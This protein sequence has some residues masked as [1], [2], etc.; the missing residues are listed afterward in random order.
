MQDERIKILDKE[1]EISIPEDRIMKAIDDMAQQMNE[2]LKGK[3]PLFLCVLNGSFMFASDLMKRITLPCEISF[4]KLSSYEGTASS[5]KIKQLLGLN[6]DLKG[7]TLVI[8]EDIIDTGLTIKNI[9]EQV[10]VFEPSV[11]K[12]ATLLFK[13]EAYKENV[14]IDYKSLI[15]PN[16][17][18]VGYGLDYDG[19]GRNLKHIYTLVSEN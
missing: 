8:L 4:M 17:F 12:V 5:G 7:R 9:I 14:T 19:F 13:P 18:I 15:I 1:F 10:K 3:Q 2:D 6:E 11:V 16:D